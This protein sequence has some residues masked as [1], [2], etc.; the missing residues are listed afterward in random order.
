MVFVLDNKDDYDVVVDVD[1]GV[2]VGFGR[3]DD[4]D[5]ICLFWAMVRW[6]LLSSCLFHRCNVFVV[7]IVVTD[8]VVV[9][10]ASLSL[11]LS[12]SV[13]SLFTIIVIRSRSVVGIVRSKE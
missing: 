3:V 13:L 1:I 12:L 10:A 4:V 11:L 7:V 5:S 2:S 9:A 8:V 6:H